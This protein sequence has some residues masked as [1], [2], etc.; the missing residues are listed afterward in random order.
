MK[1]Q[2][3]VVIFGLDGATFDLIDPLIDVGA[4][5]N[6]S[7]LLNETASGTL[8]STTPPLTGPAWTSFATGVHPGKH[9]IFDFTK[10]EGSLTEVSAATSSDISVETFYE[11]IVDAGG[12]PILVN[13]PM[14]YPPQVD[15]PVL[16]SLLTQGDETV[17]PEEYRELEDEFGEFRVSPKGDAEDVGGSLPYVEDLIQVEETR[18]DWSRRL[19]QTEDWDL[20]FHLVSATDWIQHE[21]YDELV[22]DLGTGDLSP[23]A[24][25]AVEGYEMFDEQIGW[26]REQLSEDDYFILLSDHGF[27]YYHSMFYLNGWLKKNGYLSVDEGGDASVAPTKKSQEKQQKQDVSRQIDLSRIAKTVSRYPKIFNTADWL[28]KRVSG[29]LPVDADLTYGDIDPAN[30]KSKGWG[31]IYI[32]DTD[33]FEDG[34]VSP[35]DRPEV[36]REIAEG[37]KSVVDPKTGEKVFDEV[38]LSKKVYDGPEADKAPDV[39]VTS[40]THQVDNVMSDVIFRRQEHNG[41]APEGIYSI[42]GPGVVESGGTADIVDIAPTVLALLDIG[43]PSNIDGSVLDDLFRESLQV[44]HVPPT[45]PERRGEPGESRDDSDVKERLS[46]LG[47]LDG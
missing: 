14:S 38:R 44:D 24:E 26:F 25:R 12:T 1:D 21:L 47:Y 6:L 32:N 33:R 17:F 35:E 37:L 20:F 11:R 8:R 7:S 27:R 46:D 18:F 45:T 16:T 15:S 3:S 2:P 39:V 4:M 23:A 30:S 22:S 34:I 41:H 40:T 43:V 5:P 36:A 10:F 31:G 9:G 29:Y 28:Y 19:F 42:D 13:L